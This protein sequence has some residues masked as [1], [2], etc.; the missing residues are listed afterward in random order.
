MN[1]RVSWVLYMEAYRGRE[2]LLGLWGYEMSRM[3]FLKVNIDSVTAIEVRT[4]LT[5]G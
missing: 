4:V 2:R 3:K 5:L 1:G